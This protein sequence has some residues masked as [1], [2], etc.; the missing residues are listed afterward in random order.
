MTAQ[1]VRL[2]DVRIGDTIKNFGRWVT[3]TTIERIDGRTRFYGM[4]GTVG[5]TTWFEMLD[6]ELDEEVPVRERG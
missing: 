4:Y 2:A 6:R 3:V 5:R 1:T